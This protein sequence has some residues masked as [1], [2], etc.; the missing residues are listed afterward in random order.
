MSRS[1]KSNW[2]SDYVPKSAPPITPIKNGCSVLMPT[3][4]ATKGISS[5]SLLKCLSCAIPESNHHRQYFAKKGEKDG[6]DIRSQRSSVQSTIKT[7]PTIKNVKL[8]TENSSSYEDTPKIVNPPNS[9]NAEESASPEY[10]TP[11]VQGYDES[12]PEMSIPKNNPKV[13]KPLKSHSADYI[14][15]EVTVPQKSKSADAVL[16]IPQ[17]TSE[18]DAT[19][20][21]NNP[22]KSL[23]AD[24]VNFDTVQD[25]N[26]LVKSPN[27]E[28]GQV[29]PDPE[30]TVPDTSEGADTVL[31][32]PQEASEHDATAQ[33]NNPE[34]S[35]SA[36]Y[37]QKLTTDPL[38]S[39]ISESSNPANNPDTSDLTKLQ[40]GVE[41]S[42]VN[43]DTVQDINDL[44]K[45]PNSEEVQIASNS[46]YENIP[47][48]CNDKPQSP[49]PEK[50]K[51]TIRP[52]TS[53]TP[54]QMGPIGLPH[55]GNQQDKITISIN[56]SISEKINSVHLHYGGPKSAHREGTDEE[57]TS[58]DTDV[59][60]VEYTEKAKE[61][62]WGV[63]QRLQ[64]ESEELINMT[65][66][67]ESLSNSDR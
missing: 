15:P 54:R 8:T 9:P 25:I 28:E 24:P 12:I 40:S 30:V 65:D 1:F 10:A 22:E 37:D 4:A 58:V 23:S 42:P 55:P 21:E 46:D 26:D 48:S 31:P 64:Q 52:V 66:D 27:S 44:V 17:K 62:R 45:S 19:A 51:L 38:K 33:E 7:P 6:N 50:S 61:L 59:L 34:K 60:S 49:V 36:E 47:D 67:D 29:V 53:P 43:F 3:L 32:I 63:E 5:K 20:Q 57:D 2:S 14:K 56:C 18:H 39:S 11:A 16:P 41:D 13:D 35:L